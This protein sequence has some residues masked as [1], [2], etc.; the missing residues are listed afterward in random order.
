M[1]RE[2]LEATA[3]ALASKAATTVTYTFSIGSVIAY[4]ASAQFVG[5]IGLLVALG[6]FFVNS[7]YKRKED[8]RREAADQR[9]REEHEARMKRYLAGFDPLPAAE[10]PK[11]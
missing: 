6:S 4:M 11:Q 9:E 1:V 5:F 3:A 8:R 10:G 2:A 7:Y